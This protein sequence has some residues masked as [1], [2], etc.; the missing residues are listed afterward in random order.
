M[1]PAV[2]KNELSYGNIVE[3]NFLNEDAVVK[4]GK[5]DVEWLNCCLNKACLQRN[6]TSMSYVKPISNIWKWTVTQIL[7]MIFLMKQTK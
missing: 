3:T 6:N 7:M 4:L 5:R 1:F 2:V